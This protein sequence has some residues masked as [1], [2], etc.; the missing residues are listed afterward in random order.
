MKSIMLV[1]YYKNF[2]KEVKTKLFV[3]LQLP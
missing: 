2:K 3:L 1:L